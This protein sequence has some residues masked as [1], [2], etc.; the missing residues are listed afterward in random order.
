MNFGMGLSDEESSEYGVTT[1]DLGDFDSD[2]M[3]N[4]SQYAVFYSLPAVV[5]TTGS[6]F[7]EIVDDES[8]VQEKPT[9]SKKRPRETDELDA[10]DGVA[11]QKQKKKA[12]KEKRD[13]ATI[14]NPEKKDNV[15]E[16]KKNTDNAAKSKEPKTGSSKEVKE[17]GTK[18]SKG[19]KGADKGGNEPETPK[20]KSK[21]G[22]SPTFTELPGG[23]KIHDP[24]KGSG[25]TAK[26]GSTV[27]LRYIGKLLK[28]DKNGNVASDG[29][30]FD[31]NTK[32]K[33][34]S[35]LVPII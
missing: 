27:K 29:E 9:S 28:M 33:P 22:K 25:P 4:D 20:E 31:S 3:M 26:P 16:S 14:D 19:P 11:Q 6:R 2:E 15:K 7:E 12:K 23:L 8:P 24:V 30:V 21:S 17:N 18:S 1:G 32:G 5:L 13:G 10:A 35:S 34:V